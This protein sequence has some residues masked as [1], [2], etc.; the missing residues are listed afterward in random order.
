[1]KKISNVAFS[2]GGYDSPSV[3]CLEID[4]CDVLCASQEVGTESFEDDGDEYLLF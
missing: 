2:K 1:M 4:P 3:L